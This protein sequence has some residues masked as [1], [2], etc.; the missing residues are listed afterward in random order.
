MSQAANQYTASKGKIFITL[1]PSLY[2]A[3]LKSPS[4]FE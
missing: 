3:S 4:H 1:T 2:L